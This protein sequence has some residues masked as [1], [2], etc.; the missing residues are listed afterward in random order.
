MWSSFFLR[1]K[2]IYKLQLL[3]E[4]AL[5]LT[6]SCGALSS[7]LSLSWWIKTNMDL[8]T[9]LV[10]LIP[11]IVS[12]CSLGK[13]SKSWL[14]GH[15]DTLCWVFSSAD[16][17]WVNQGFLSLAGTCL[18]PFAAGNS[19]FRVTHPL[20]PIHPNLWRHFFSRSSLA[21]GSVETT[22]KGNLSRWPEC[23]S[24]PLSFQSLNGVAVSQIL[25]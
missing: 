10:N 21:H 25:T 6:V 16:F 11:K 1:K 4:Q 22:S 15:L 3:L 19:F 20:T 18:N 13:R 17:K 12:R 23:L 24:M 2:Q 7:L 14:Y 8:P 9:L 5:A